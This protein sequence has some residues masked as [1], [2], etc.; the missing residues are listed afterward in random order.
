MFSLFNH[1]LYSWPNILWSYNN[2]ICLYKSLIFARCKISNLKICSAPGIYVRLIFRIEYLLGTLTKANMK[3]QNLTLDYNFLR[4]ENKHFLEFENQK[5]IRPCK[6]ICG[7]PEKI[8]EQTMRTPV[9]IQ[10]NWRWF[11]FMGYFPDKETHLT[12]L[13]F[14]G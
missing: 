12:C 10:D 11:P 8:K 14:Y 9:N 1:I 3:D 2:N 6:N 5:K 7:L 4:G 13:F